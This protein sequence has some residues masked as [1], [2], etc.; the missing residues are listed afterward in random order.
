MVVMFVVCLFCVLLSLLVGLCKEIPEH[1]LKLCIS[2]Y[3]KINWHYLLIN[4]A[5]HHTSEHIFQRN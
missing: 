2:P 5:V 4:P 3:Y 1:N